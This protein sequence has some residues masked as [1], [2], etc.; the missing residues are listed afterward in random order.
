MTR[1]DSTSTLVALYIHGSK[2]FTLNII[3]L[4]IAS[5]SGSDFR[6]LFIVTSF[7]DDP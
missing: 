3:S 1:D 5:P 7:I 2:C 6:V 4:T